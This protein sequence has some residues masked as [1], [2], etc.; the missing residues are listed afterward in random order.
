[1]NAVFVHARS[2]LVIAL[3]EHARAL[4]QHWFY[5]R[6]TY[7]SSRETSLTNYGETKMWTAKNISHTHFITSID[8]HE[9]EVNDGLKRVRL[10]LNAMTSGCKELDYFSVP[11]FHTIAVASHQNVNKHTLMLICIQS[12]FRFYALNS[13]IVNVNKFIDL[14]KDAIE[15]YFK[16]RIDPIIKLTS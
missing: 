14:N 11:C 16:N 8:H 4:V 3:F 5:E 1:M 10:N 12:S 6:Q 7:A 2:S 13:W 9:L 15:V